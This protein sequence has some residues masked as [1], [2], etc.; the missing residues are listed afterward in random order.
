ML[1]KNIEEIR[2]CLTKGGKVVSFE[3]R[4]IWEIKKVLPSGKLLCT[5]GIDDKT[6]EFFLFDDWTLFPKK[7]ENARLTD[8][9]IRIPHG[10]YNGT[11][12]GYVV[13]FQGENGLLYE[14]RASKYMRKCA[15]CLVVID[16][17]GMKV[18]VINGG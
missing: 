1:A 12:D 11:W 14:S 10:K 3:S 6:I 18:K 2:D 16:E 4:T 5:N 8:V 15:A 13:T 17:H 7:D 9:R